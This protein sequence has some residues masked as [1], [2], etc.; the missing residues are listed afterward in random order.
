MASKRVS[1]PSLKVTRRPAFGKKSVHFEEQSFEQ[2]KE[3]PEELSKEEACPT[4][5]DV[6]CDMGGLCDLLEPSNLSTT[7]E[8]IP[9]CHELE[10]RA[11]SL[12]W[13]SLRPKLYTSVTEVSAMPLA[14]ICLCC[15][16]LASIRCKQCSINAFFCSECFTSSHELV[17]IFHVAE[18]WEVT[19]YC[20]QLMATI[21]NDCDLPLE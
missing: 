11:S 20:E 18:K 15:D 1:L 10:S 12:A 3:G 21:T 16:A 9:T 8:V 19:A 7:T 2:L 6:S 14:Q 13:E 5:M 4:S 17:N